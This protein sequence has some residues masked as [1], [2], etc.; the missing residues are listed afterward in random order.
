GYEPHDEP[1]NNDSLVL[2]MSY[3]KT[4]V[5]LEGDAESPIERGMLSEPDLD[6]SLLKIGHHGSAT[7]TKPEFLDRVAPRSAIISC[8]LHNH[9]GHPR[10][11]V[12][13]A[14]QAAHVR[15]LSTDINGTSCFTLNG[16]SV[17]AEAFCG[18]PQK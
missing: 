7:S 9:Y 6:S 12:L 17:E 10:Q 8:G 1:G 4:S 3:Q 14:L 15:T 16:E 18:M 2:K 5:L 13:A 11:E